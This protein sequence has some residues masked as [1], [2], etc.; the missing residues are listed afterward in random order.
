[1]KLQ[2]KKQQ[3]QEDAAQSVIKCFEGQSNGNIR[4]VIGKRHCVINEGTMWEEEINEDIISFGNRSIELSSEEIRKNIRKVQ[5]QNNLDYTDNEGITNFSI[6]ME[7]GTGKTYTYIKTIYEL[8]KAYGWSKFIVMTPSIAIR[9]GVLKS[10]KITQEHFQELYGKKIRYFVYN[11]NNSSNLSNINNFVEDNNI[12][13]MIINYQAFNTRSRENRKIYEELDELQ[14]RKPIDVIKATNPILIVDEPQKMGKTEQLLNEFN[15]L[16]ILRYSATHK[17]GYKYNMIYRLD[18]VDAY[19]QKLVK[20]INVKGIEILHEKSESAYLYLESVEISKLNPIAKVE[21]DVKSSKGTRK[22][23]KILTKGAN[24]Y[25]ISGGLEQYKGYIISEIDAQN[26]EYDRILFTNGEELRAGQVRGNSKENYMARIQIKETIKS[27]FEK[28]EEY[29]KKGIKVLSLF[30]IDEVEKYKK[31]DENKKPYNGQYAE[32]FEEEYNNIYNE[33]YKNF[34]DDYKKYLETLKDK[35]VHC[36]YFSVD[37][38]ASKGLSKD[39]LVYI[40]SKIDDKKEGTSADE[41]AYNLIMRDK[42]RLL[43]LN[44]PIR[45]IFSHSALREGWDNPNIFQICTLKR[46]KSEISK[47]QEIGRGLRICVDNNGDRMD[48]QEIEDEFFKINNLTVIASESYEIFANA[49]QNEMAESL[50]RKSYNTFSSKHFYG[51]ILNNINGEAKS[52]DERAINQIYR[53]FIK[54]EYI[55]D[56]DNITEKFKE[57]IANN[58][59]DIPDEFF[60]YK[61]QYIN[62]IKNLYTDIVVPIE[63][64]RKKDIK[65]LKPNEKFES[66][67]FKELWDKINFKTT[68]EV[69]FN[70]SKLIDKA[71]I[72]LND[73]LK[74]SKMRAKMTEGEQKEGITVNEIREATAMYST[75]IK[76][77]IFEDNTQVNTKYDLIGNISK[78][79]GLTRHTI[80][81]ILSKIEPKVFEQYEYNPEEFIRKASNLIN[82]IKAIIISDGISYK[83]TG[84]KFNND[85]FTIKNAYGRI[86]DNAFETKRHIYDFV[87]TDSKNELKFASDL[88]NGEVIIYAKLPTN[89]KIPTPIG[90][91]S[92]DWAIVLNSEKFG[93]KYVIVET[94]G[95]MSSNELRPIENVKTKCAKKHFQAICNNDVEYYVVDSYDSLISEIINCN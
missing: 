27:H 67:P 2:F 55:D 53:N 45:F 32:I 65:E 59:I 80:I 88:E 49:L 92:P 60:N 44:E 93:L 15:P 94:K 10:F 29:Y 36:G 30:F 19:N 34:D 4:S 26:Q 47:R 64:L 54:N 62:L 74:I 84:D 86:N 8:N 1:M 48:Y 20:K 50:S 56:N 13:V 37:K 75:K 95:S 22:A 25:E 72:E 3:Y 70:S 78:E 17:N 35:K 24:L 12:Q 51:K 38:K 73:K 68:Y 81:E 39:E 23:T 91:Y 16:F 14:S 79:T 90:N 31:Y 11:S 18:A 76:N 41:D 71:V 61:E 6:E 58:E 66:S 87:V 40:D 7:T 33:Y 85:I 42:E 77:E 57:A 82:E 89:F 28:E 63:N 21:I 69:N 83:K 46:S 5:K 9:E 52:L 43:S